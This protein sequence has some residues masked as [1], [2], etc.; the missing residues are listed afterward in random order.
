MIHLFR[1]IGSLLDSI[2]VEVL[3]KNAYGKLRLW[4][5]FFIFLIEFSNEFTML[6]VL[7][8]MDLLLVSLE[9]Q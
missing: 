6:G 3:P 5:Y 7:S 4:Y 8:D 1:S 9:S 2:Q